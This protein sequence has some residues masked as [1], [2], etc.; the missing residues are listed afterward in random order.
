[1][2]GAETAT[3]GENG[4]RVIIVYETWRWGRMLQIEWID[5]I[6]DNTVF[7]W[8]KEERLLLKLLK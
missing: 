2:C 1:V 6:T 7:Q 3:V 8:A 5:R 4:E